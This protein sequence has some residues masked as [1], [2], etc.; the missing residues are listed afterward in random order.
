MLIQ[1]VCQNLAWQQELNMREKKRKN[2]WNCNCKGKIPHFL[3]GQL[4][5]L[6]SAS[7]VCSADLRIETTKVSRL[8]EFC[9]DSV[10]LMTQLKLF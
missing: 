6:G 5:K 10:T 7:E 3:G 9:S 1:K 4:E 2:L 8:R